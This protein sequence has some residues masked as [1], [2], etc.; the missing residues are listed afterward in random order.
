M[1]GTLFSIVLFTIISLVSSLT[2]SEYHSQNLFINLP[3]NISVLQKIV[4]SVLT[5]DSFNDTGWI[6][7]ECYHL[8]Q[9]LVDTPVGWY[10]PGT[11]GW[12]V[13]TRISV[14]YEGA[15]PGQYI[16]DINTDS[17]FQG[18]LEFLGCE[19]QSGINCHRDN[20]IERSYYNNTVSQHLVS[21]DGSRIDGY[22]SID[23]QDKTDPS[24]VAWIMEHYDNKY[25]GK[26]GEKVYLS[27]DNGSFPTYP[28]SSLTVISF[29]TDMIKNRYGI[30]VMDLCESGNCFLGPDIFYWI[31]QVM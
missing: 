20:Q 27:K 14:S 8:D 4:P 9:V 7:L 19:T 1:I 17:N 30:D 11:T 10:S 5:V 23:T 12:T 16:L 6:T 15:Y 26:L 29:T 18:T 3:L 31:V 22:F 21:D 13:K 25:V 2:T 24:L 28:I